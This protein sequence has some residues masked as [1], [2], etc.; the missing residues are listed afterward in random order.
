MSCMKWSD[1]VKKKFVTLLIILLTSISSVFSQQNPI[2]ATLKKNYSSKTSL[3][4]G[5]DLNIFWVVREKHDK[6]AGSLY[7]AP[8]EKFRLKLGNS[9]WISDGHTYWQ[10]N[11]GVSQV[12]IKNLLDV[13]LSMH[14]SMMIQS[15]LSYSFKT[16]SQNDKEVVLSWKSS[17]NKN[18]KDYKLIRLWIDRKKTIFKKILVVDKNNNENTYTFK[19]TKIGGKI[20]IETFDFKIP[21]GVDILDTRN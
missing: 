16:D 8:G 15:Y 7:F 6:K 2:L 13:D 11:R 18:S 12:I 4:L 5:F 21:K 1:L 9:E 14:P 10:Y 17:D 19:K 20:P 3:E